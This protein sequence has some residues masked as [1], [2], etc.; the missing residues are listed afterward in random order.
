MFMKTI[1]TAGIVSLAIAAAL[2]A[3]PVLADE[4]PDTLDGFRII[5]PE[6]GTATGEN[7]I[8][9]LVPYLRGHPESLEGRPGV[10]L[11]ISASG[12][13]LVADI[14]LTGYLDDSVAG[15]HY[16]GFIVQSPGGWELTDLGVTPICARGDATDGLCP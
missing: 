9:I 4:E 8:D 13:R 16:R 10:S 5:T 11:T 6:P 7:V 3:T 2:A 15:E 14:V 1:K 12:E